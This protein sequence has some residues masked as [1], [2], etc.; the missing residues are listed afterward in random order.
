MM[1]MMMMLG[2]HTNLFRVA[3]IELCQ[4][5]NTNVV[6]D[7]DTRSGKNEFHNDGNKPVSS[8]GGFV[9]K[10]YTA[11]AATLWNAG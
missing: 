5:P 11:T 9:D 3:T 6:I 10:P 2:G 7:R 1:M 4:E 8:N